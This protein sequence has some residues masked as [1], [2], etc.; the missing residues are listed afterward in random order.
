MGKA[1]YLE[2]GEN[3]RFIVTNLD[4]EYGSGKD[5]YEKLYCG[6][7]DME[8]RIKEQQLWLFSDRTSTELM[9]SNQLRLWFSSVAYVLIS[10]LRRV[11]LKGT[12]MAKA[13]VGTIRTKIFKIGAQVKV[14]VRRVYISLSSGYPYSN[15]F[16]TILRN[17]KHH[18][19]FLS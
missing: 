17:I 16:Y 3:P 5:L 9:R 1:E 4:S 2:K 14:S 8:N 7:G 10:E 15:L 19:C 11:G 18:Y 6:R 13:Q 12:K